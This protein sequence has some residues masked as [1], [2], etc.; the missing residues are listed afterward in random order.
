MCEYIGNPVTEIGMGLGKR[1]KWAQIDT[2]RVCQDCCK[3]NTGL[4]HVTLYAFLMSPSPKA[5]GGSVCQ[6]YNSRK[7]SV[8]GANDLRSKHYSL[9]KPRARAC[10]TFF[11]MLMYS[12]SYLTYILLTVSHCMT[13]YVPQ[14]RSVSKGVRTVGR[15]AQK[16]RQR[17]VI[18]I[19]SS[20]EL[21]LP[22]F[23]EPISQIQYTPEV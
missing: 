23:H 3:K 11:A 17:P 2:G 7:V 5:F 19:L 15:T 13:M 6:G 4:S 1:L 20:P 9:L 12:Y 21:F 22:P 18:F 10:N 16:R 14:I 8:I